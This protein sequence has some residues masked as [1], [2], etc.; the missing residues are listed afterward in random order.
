METVKRLALCTL[1]PKGILGKYG[2]FPYHKQAMPF[3]RYLRCRELNQVCDFCDQLQGVL[4][5]PAD[6][7]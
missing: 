5:L 1:S 2:N 6:L 4:S 3:M 7:V